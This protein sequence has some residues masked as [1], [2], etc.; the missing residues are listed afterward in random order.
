MLIFIQ[1]NEHE[2]ASGYEILDEIFLFSGGLLL[3]GTLIYWSGCSLWFEI[4][5]WPAPGCGILQP[6]V[7]GEEIGSGKTPCA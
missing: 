4:R 2:V 7:P 1:K 5:T 3:P 6:A